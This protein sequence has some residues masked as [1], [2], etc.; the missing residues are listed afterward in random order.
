[1]ATESQ[2]NANRR[3]SAKSTGPRT[4]EGKSQSSG[5]ALKHG[6]CVGFRVMQAE[7]Q[8]EVDELIAEYWRDFA[9]A[10]C[11]IPVPISTRV[12]QGQKRRPVVAGFISAT[13]RPR[14]SRLGGALQLRH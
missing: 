11:E 4:P 5:N 7:N 6:L 2:I 9:P 8:E 10:N 12:A 3:N 13:L 14:A 1:M